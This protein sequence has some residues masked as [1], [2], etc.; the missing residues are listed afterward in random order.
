MIYLRDLYV[1]WNDGGLSSGHS[2]F[3]LMGGWRLYSVDDFFGSLVP[4]F[5][6]CLHFC[7]S[8][9]VRKEVRAHG[10]VRCDHRFLTKSLPLNKCSYIQFVN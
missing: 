1:H 3:W 6:R 10:P 8:A 7:M 9:E 5:R 2:W 4:W